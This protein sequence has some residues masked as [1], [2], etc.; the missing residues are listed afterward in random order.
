MHH[1]LLILSTKIHTNTLAYTHIHVQASTHTD[2]EFIMNS[3]HMHAHTRTDTQMHTR[4]HTHTHAHTHTRTHKANIA[5][6]A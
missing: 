5:N 1:C 4:M 3:V 6:R 2:Q